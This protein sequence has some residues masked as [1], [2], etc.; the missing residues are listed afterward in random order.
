[1]GFR[2]LGFRVI[3]YIGFRVWGYIGFRVLG[4][5]VLGLGLIRFRVGLRGRAPWPKKSSSFK[6]IV[7]VINKPLERY[8]LPTQPLSREFGLQG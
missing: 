6:L 8:R 2:V 7:R 5:R 4:F 3:Y 1:M